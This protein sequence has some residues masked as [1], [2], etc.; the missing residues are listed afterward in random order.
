MNFLSLIT[1]E[2][3]I[4][5]LEISASA[6]RIAFLDQGNKKAPAHFVLGTE[7]LPLGTITD[8]KIAD[9]DAFV[10]ALKTLLKKV[11]MQ[12]RYFIVSIPL[13]SGYTKIINF[14]A[15]L[16]EEHLREAVHLA[17]PFQLPWKEEDSYIDF[18][19]VVGTE[20]NTVFLAAAPK[21]IINTYVDALHDSDIKAI[22]VEF[23]PQSLLR[24]ITNENEPKILIIPEETSSVLTIIQNETLEFTRILPHNRYPDNE[25]IT[26]ETQK[27][28]NYY[29]AEHQI[30][31]SLLSY[32]ACTLKEDYA[33]LI[34]PDTE[35]QEYF[36]TIG[37][38]V[39][40]AL[41]RRNDRMMSLLPVSTETMYHQQNAMAFMAFVRTV[42]IGICLFFVGGYAGVWMLMSSI[43]G[44]SSSRIQNNSASD[45]IRADE[46]RA[47]DFNDFIVATGPLTESH[48]RWSIFID[49]FKE[50]I[51]PGITVS[52]ITLGLPESPIQISGL[53]D[54]RAELNAFK[55]SLEGRSEF[56]G[57]SLPLTN[58]A[59]KEHIPFTLTLSL[60]DPK[61]LY[62][63]P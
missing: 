30:F 7:P 63:H 12:T 3:P 48:V 49:S 42:T 57:V 8:G 45:A 13:E 35:V 47:R 23:A 18:E 41:P 16:S 34:P 1:R 5:G 21:D 58:I 4:G 33:R 20:Q 52:N 39:R 40:G 28:Q 11:P 53:A 55:K 19:R 22:A 25:T 31:P 43:E 38:A 6:L 36:A 37:A 17:L 24:A 60:T 14:P 29:Q 32:G 56:T 26:A 54:T 51:T 62:L 46:A 44:N 2:E 10:T 9:R 27:I 59:Q 15:A 50:K 61:S